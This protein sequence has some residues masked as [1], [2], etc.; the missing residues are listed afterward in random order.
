MI[1]NRLKHLINKINQKTKELK[2]NKTQK[3]KPAESLVNQIKLWN[4]GYVK[5]PMTPAV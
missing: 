3:N 4:N 5:Y 2:P 1:N